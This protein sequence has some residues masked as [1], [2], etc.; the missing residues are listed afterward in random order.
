MSDGLA[1]QAAELYSAL[2]PEARTAQTLPQLLWARAAGPDRH[3]PAL[4]H[5]EF[6]IW[7]Q[8]TWEEYAQYV[9]WTAQG[10]LALGLKPGETVAVIADNIPEWYY[11]ELAAQAIGAVVAGIY[12]SSVAREVAYGVQATGAVLVLAEDQEQVDK[13]LE[14]RDQIPQVRRVIYED[15][16]GMR[17]YRDDPWFLS[18]QELL[19]LGKA[20]GGQHPDAVDRLVAQGDPD[21]VCL[22]CF[23]SGTTD[24]PK[25]V[26]L[27][28][29]NVLAMGRHFTAIEGF[30]PGDDYLSFLP[31]AWMGEQMMAVATGLV[32]GF[33]V[34]CPEEVETID[35][36]LREIGPHLIFSPPRVWEAQ[37]RQIRVKME[38]STWLKRQVFHWGLHVG[39]KVA[40]LRFAGQPVPLSLKL[41]HRFFHFALYRLVQ[42]R[43][44]FLR[45]RKAYTAGAALGPDVFRFFHA[46]GVNLKQG[47]GQ[48][49]T[50]G[51]FC[52]HRDGDIKFETVG[53]PFP[54]VEVKVSDQ[55]EIMVRGEIVCRGYYGRDDAT[56]AAFTDGWLHTGD[57][58]Y[59]DPD[60][61]L[62]IIDR[63]QDVMRTQGGEVFS[64][65]FIEN[66]LK[67]SHYI[68]EAVVFGD[69]LP[70]VAA[71]INI[72]AATVGKWA[73]DRR[74]SYTTYLDLSQKPEVARLIREEVARVNARL[75]PEHR[76]RRF[77]L[78]Y[79]LLDA[80]D[81]ELTRTGKV[82]RTLIAQRYRPLFE[83]LYD[84]RQEVPVRTTFHYQDG[85]VQELEVRVAIQ[86][87]TGEEAQDGLPAAAAG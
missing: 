78:L 14:V 79:K 75:K 10:L 62:V 40:D 73:E 74:I 47:Y 53:T 81:E 28:H 32:A 44:G 36:D 34:N 9:R 27:T 82:R 15:P 20:Y 22:M 59:I 21:A 52:V 72:D 25:P 70:Y 24:L 61:H 2:S 58:G 17:R 71:L 57:A 69:G 64:P 35:H 3:R 55:G 37:M 11:M 50:S 4:R 86:S 13:L 43:F 26:M 63:L 65:Q 1:A 60:G 85:R 42:D 77:A 45:L 18:F 30:R 39:L 49:E 80:D 38:D 66:K 67:F 23:S 29:R 83:A 46:L 7:N 12:Q 84:G 5:K 6:G 33:T 54:G 76:I 41:L 51:I 48:T 56:Q 87:L 8:I 68:K 16:R 19:E 31:L